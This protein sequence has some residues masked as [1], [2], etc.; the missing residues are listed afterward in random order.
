M[1]KNSERQAKKEIEIE[2][3]REFGNFMLSLFMYIWGGESFYNMT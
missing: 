2:N 1:D 3:K